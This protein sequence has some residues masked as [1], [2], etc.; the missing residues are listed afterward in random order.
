MY[1][2]GTKHKH[3]VTE[4]SEEAA[5]CTRSLVIKLIRR[6]YWRVTR[7]LVS[8]TRRMKSRKRGRSTNQ[9]EETTLSLSVSISLPTAK[10]TR[11][12]SPCSG[13][14]PCTSTK[15]AWVLL[16][17]NSSSITLSSSA[18]AS[19]KTVTPLLQSA[20]AAPQCPKCPPFAV[21]QPSALYPPLPHTL[22]PQPKP[23]VC[24]SDPPSHPPF[25]RLNHHPLS[26]KP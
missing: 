23:P 21:P 15:L 25:L 13:P 12:H 9:V 14:A 17:T 2:L 22:N 20:S 7:R 11:A 26:R 4:C 5:R 18:R 1:T 16:P 6:V 3:T 10:Y 8:E 19:L 24:T